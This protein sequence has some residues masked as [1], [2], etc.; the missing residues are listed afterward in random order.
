MTSLARRFVLSDFILWLI[1]ALTF[2]S[3]S[4]SYMPHRP[5]FEE[6]FPTYFF[7][8][9][10]LREIDSGTG[11]GLR[12]TLITLT[13]AIQSRAS[14]CRDPFVRLLVGAALRS[15]SNIGEFPS[16]GYYLLLVCV[17]SFLQ[18]YIV[19]FLLGYLTRPVS[20]KGAQTNAFNTCLAQ[21]YDVD[22]RWQ[23]CNLGPGKIKQGV[24]PL[25]PCTSHLRV[26]PAL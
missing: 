21:R 15:T 4:D 17:L 3:E 24:P 9:R 11:V 23:D 19:G 10:A 18:W 8:G 20:A 22:H 12:P 1:F 2:A 6:V 14:S 7:F 16:G 26:I 25:V 13:F 5:Y